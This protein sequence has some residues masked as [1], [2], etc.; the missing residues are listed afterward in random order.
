MLAELILVGK[1]LGKTDLS[2]STPSPVARPKLFGR[3]KQVITRPTISKP[4]TKTGPA[5]G[6]KK[7][8]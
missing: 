1:L 3:D 2:K 8:F 6:L 5:L 7:Y 4:P